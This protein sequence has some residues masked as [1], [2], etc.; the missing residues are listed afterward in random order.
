MCLYLYTK[1]QVSS[2][3]LTSLRHG[4][5]LPLHLHLKANPPKSPP[6]LGLKLTM[7]KAK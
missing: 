2:L 1:F 7:E 4:G 6:R 5:I 3:I